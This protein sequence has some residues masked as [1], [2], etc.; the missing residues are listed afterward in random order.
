MLFEVSRSVGVELISLLNEVNF[1]FQYYE[2]NGKYMLT[3]I[4][5]IPSQYFV[6]AEERAKHMLEITSRHGDLS[7][8]QVAHLRH[9]SLPELAQERQ[10]PTFIDLPLAEVV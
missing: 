8:E 10:R 5:V 1:D 3:S 9:M 6:D 7:E 2:L 4:T